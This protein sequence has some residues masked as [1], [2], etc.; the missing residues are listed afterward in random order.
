MRHGPH[1]GAQQSNR[2]TPG[3]FRISC[4][5]LWSVT[6][7]GLLEPAAGATSVAPHFP[8]LAIR[9]ARVLASTRFLVPHFS[10]V[11]IGMFKIL[12][13]VRTGRMIIAQQL[14]AG[15]GSRIS[16]PALTMPT[17]RYKLFTSNTTPLAKVLQKFGSEVSTVY[18]CS[19][20]RL[21]GNTYNCSSRLRS[22]AR[23]FQPHQ[24]RHRRSRCAH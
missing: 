14:T 15:R 18:Y 17:I 13:L 11:T 2:T 19:W 16:Y 4:E 1:H 12:Q 6:V 5:K 8:H 9:S 22:N 23:H 7:N 21:T 24:F 20:L 10:H 3:V